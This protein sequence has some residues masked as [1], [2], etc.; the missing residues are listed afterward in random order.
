M[1]GALFILMLMH[2]AVTTYTY[3]TLTT[4]YKILQKSPFT[5]YITKTCSECSLN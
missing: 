1:E 4:R 5:Y 2:T 3:N